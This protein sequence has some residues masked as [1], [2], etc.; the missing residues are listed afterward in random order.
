MVSSNNIKENNFTKVANLKDFQEGSLMK[1]QVKEKSIVL[2]MVNGQIHAMNSVCSHQGGPLEEGT[3]E[4]YN[5]T[6]P[7]HYAVFDIRNG[8]VSDSTVWA[9]DLESYEVKQDN[10]TG[11]IFL[12]INNFDKDNL[13]S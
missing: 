9:T 2:A 7:L 6:C 13:Y 4:G 3:L 8:K 11:D 12:N 5:I 1:V 10:K